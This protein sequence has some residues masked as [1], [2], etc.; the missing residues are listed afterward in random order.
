MAVRLFMARKS[1][2]QSNSL[3]DAKEKA[4]SGSTINKLLHVIASLSLIAA[5]IIQIDTSAKYASASSNWIKAGSIALG[6]SYSNLSQSSLMTGI[7]VLAIAVILLL[8]SLAQFLPEES[9]DQHT[10]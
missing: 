1:Y 2:A 10:A 9:E 3:A 6:S 8:V 7:A 5:G 4:M